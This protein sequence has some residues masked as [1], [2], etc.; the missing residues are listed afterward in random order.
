MKKVG[1]FSLLAVSACALAGCGKGLSKEEAVKFA[2]DNFATGAA[3][4]KEDIKFKRVVK[5]NTATGL[6]EAFKGDEEIKEDK[7]AVV[8][9][10][11]IGIALLADDGYKFSTFAG[12]LYADK[13]LDGAEL[14]EE[15]LSIKVD[16][17]DVSGKS[18]E[19][20]V[21]NK[22]GFELSYKGEYNLKFNYKSILTGEEVK[23]EL[24]SSIEVTYSI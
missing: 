21:Y 4:I 23:S 22:E 9:E 14:I 6:F 7:M 12:K 20:Y 5:V 13:D 15:M 8:A 16:S 3:G 1:L 2:E 17:K 10:N 24:K 18:S 19:H 11:A